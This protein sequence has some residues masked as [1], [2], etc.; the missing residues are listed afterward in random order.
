MDHQGPCCHQS[1]P[2]RFRMIS[3]NSATCETCAKKQIKSVARTYDRTID[4]GGTT[5]E[6]NLAEVRGH[7]LDQDTETEACT[8]ESLTTMWLRQMQQRRGEEQEKALSCPT[9]TKSERKTPCKPRRGWR[10][11]RRLQKERRLDVMVKKR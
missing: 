9:Q 7:D 11:L 6:R 3:D 2:P 5:Q 4:P 1:K 10:R 8:S